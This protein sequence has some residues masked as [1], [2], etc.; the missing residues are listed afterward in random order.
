MSVYLFP[1][2]C[3][4]PTELNFNPF[5]YCLKFTFD[6]KQNNFIPIPPDMCCLQ[7]SHWAYMECWPIY[8]KRGPLVKIRKKINPNFKFDWENA[9]RKEKFPALRFTRLVVT[10][11]FKNPLGQSDLP[12]EKKKY[13]LLFDCPHKHLTNTCVQLQ[14]SY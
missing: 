10:Y 8:N 4:L 9:D 3:K 2:L 5:N 6:T 12:H 11:T 7:S 13:L 1:S 14:H